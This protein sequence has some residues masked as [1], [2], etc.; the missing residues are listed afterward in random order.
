MIETLLDQSVLRQGHEISFILGHKIL[1]KTSQDWFELQGEALNVSDW[2]DLKDFCLHSNEKIQLE[3]KG[4]VTGLYQ[5]EKYAW[6]FSFVEKKDCFRAYLSAFKTSDDLQ[7]GIEYPLFWDSVKK[8]KGLFIIGGERRQGKSTLLGEIIT[9]V[10]NNKMSLTGIHSVNQ[11]QKWPQLD[12]IVHLGADSVDWESQHILYEGLERI[13]VD[14]NNVK[15]WKKWIEFAEQGQSVF[16]SVGLNSITTL[17]YKLASDL[18]E[19]MMS[20]FI[21]VFNGA[22]VQ[23]LASANKVALHEILVCREKEKKNL[24]RYYEQKQNFQLLNLTEISTEAYQTLNQSILQR[25]IRRKLD[26]QSAFA[27][28]DAPDDLDAQ[29]KK[30]GL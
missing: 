25:M 22:I 6:R 28:S 18:D 19:S 17:L 10:Q 14:F 26:V 7:S 5:S 21:Q 20:R 29:L 11:Q 23:K 4:F 15:N 13:I 2:E 1:A 9:N 8:D 3:T 16:I 30:M 12:S 27:V 24:L